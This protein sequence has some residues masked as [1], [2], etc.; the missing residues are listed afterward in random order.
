M[1]QGP[2]YLVPIGTVHLRGKDAWIEIFPPYL[3]GMLGLEQFSHIHVLYWL[4]EN[5]HEKERAVLQVHPRGNKSNPLTGV[6]ATHSP[7]RPNPVALTRCRVKSV[8]G[9]RIVVDE[10]DAFDGSPV[11]DIKSFF[12]D[13]ARAE[14]YRVPR[15]KKGEDGPY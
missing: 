5:D 13:E 6:F 1:K 15:W 2:F 14:T 8:E 7:R 10:I 12:P 3:D 11:I 4:H 9:N